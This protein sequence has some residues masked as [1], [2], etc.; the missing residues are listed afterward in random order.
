MNSHH[1]NSYNDHEELRYEITNGIT[2]C[3]ACHKNFHKIYGKGWNTHEQ[4]LSFK[5]E[6]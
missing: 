5:L 6:F 2:L 4:F 3:T 1:L